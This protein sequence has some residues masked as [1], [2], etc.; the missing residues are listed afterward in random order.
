MASSLTITKKRG[1][2]KAFSTEENHISLQHPSV[3]QVNA[4][5][6]QVRSLSRQGDT[7]LVQLND[8]RQYQFD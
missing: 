3:V 5:R 4:Y 1:N 7:L 2:H 8:G 6:S